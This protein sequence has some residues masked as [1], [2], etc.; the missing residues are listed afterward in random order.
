M[1]KLS[2]RVGKIVINPTRFPLTWLAFAWH[3]FKKACW[4]GERASRIFFR[5]DWDE[6]FRDQ[7]KF[8]HL[9]GGYQLTALTAAV[10][11]AALFHLLIETFD[12]MYKKYGFSYAEMSANIDPVTG[13]T[14]LARRKLFLSI[15]IDFEK[16]QGGSL[17]AVSW[18]G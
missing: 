16:L 9:P 5:S 18:Y 14:Q 15:D 4:S 7:V 11:Y 13:A 2:R 12:G 10:A 6:A 17:R 8:G 1:V 3:Y